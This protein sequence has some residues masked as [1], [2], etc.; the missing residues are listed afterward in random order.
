MSTVDVRFPA[1]SKDDP[2]AEG[3]VGTWFVR[4]G[5]AVKA[6]QVI[7]EVQVEKVSQDVEAEVDG[8]IRLL[9]AEEEPVRQGAVIATIE[10]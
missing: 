3:I 7:A 1:M 8:V 9:V 10:S 6:G 2:D 5:Q 4:D